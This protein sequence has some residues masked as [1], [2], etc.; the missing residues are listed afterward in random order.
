MRALKA[1]LSLGVVA[2]LATAIIVPMAWLYTVST[3][4]NVIDSS[5]DIETHL[6]QSIESERHGMRSSLH[7]GELGTMKWERPDFTRLPKRLVA[8]FITET[9]CPTFFQTP[10]EDGFPWMKRLAAK[11]VLGRQL[12]GDGACELL[13]SEALARRLGAVTSLQV[14]VASERIHR[15][16]QKDQLVA[17]NLMSFQ[18]EPGLVGVEDA[19]RELLQKEL[20]EMNDAELAELQLAIPPWGYWSD[21]KHCVN[22]ALVRQSRDG[23]LRRLA[24]EGM[25]SEE[26]A[27][28]AAAQPPRC[29][30]V[31]R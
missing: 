30:S 1:F 10:R 7:P 26:M 15:F 16:L 18:F 11:A 19:A 2:M 29:L 23:L 21:V 8:L 22:A 17:M 9:G 14:T 31:R 4:P 27:K 13:F 28:S 20:S 25:M 3:L 12:D 5:L 6:R 24:G